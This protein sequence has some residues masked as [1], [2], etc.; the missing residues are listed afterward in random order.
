MLVCSALVD[1]LERDGWTLHGNIFIRDGKRM[2]PLYE[3]KMIHHFDHR[4]ATY[5]RP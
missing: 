5:E 4:L 2:L 3:A 1:Q